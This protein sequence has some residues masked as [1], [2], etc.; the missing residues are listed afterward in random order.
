MKTF[1]TEGPVSPE[2]NY[3]VSRS[4][5]LTDFIDR[6][7]QGKY[8]VIFAPRQTG[9][10]T[11]FQFALDMLV[12]ED[13]TYFPIELN[14]ETYEGVDSGD[15]YANFA[16]DI[17]EAVEDSFQMRGEAPPTALTQFLENTQITSHLSMRRFFREFARLLENKRIVIIID[18]FDGIPQ[19]AVKGFLHSLR[20]IYLSK[21]PLRCPYSLGVVQERP[22]AS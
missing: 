18:E 20:H 22:S 10:T 16:E 13:P 1:G 17:R 6:I 2:R 11:F 14:F 5:E 21:V 7:K 3:V 9:K 12:A 8:L 15:F 19:E 4:A